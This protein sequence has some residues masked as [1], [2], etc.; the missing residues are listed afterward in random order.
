MKLK[1]V[2]KNGVEI[3]AIIMPFDIIRAGFVEELE[4]LAYKCRQT[5]ETNKEREYLKAVERETAAR[6]RQCKARES[7]WAARKRTRPRQRE[8]SGPWRAEKN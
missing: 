8:W 7:V 2:A 5:L 4:K 1:I 3:A 6:F